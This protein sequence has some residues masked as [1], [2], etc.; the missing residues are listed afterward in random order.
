MDFLCCESSVNLCSPITEAYQSPVNPDQR[1]QW[2]HNRDPTCCSGSQEKT[3]EPTMDDWANTPTTAGMS[4]Y[5]GELSVLLV[6]N[7]RKEEIFWFLCQMDNPEASR[8]RTPS[9][10]GLCVRQSRSWNS[11]ILTI[12]GSSPCMSNVKKIRPTQNNADF[13]Q[14]LANGSHCVL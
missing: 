2:N 6:P 7:T 10:R 4:F 3:W 11:S 8:N 5:I 12:G 14:R 1:K 13:G 9:P